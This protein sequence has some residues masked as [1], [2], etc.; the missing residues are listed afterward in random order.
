M[1]S[2]KKI[3][4]TSPWLA[5][6]L[7]KVC[8]PG[9]RS[10]FLNGTNSSTNRK[11]KLARCCVDEILLTCMLSALINRQ[12]SSYSADCCC[13]QVAANNIV[14]ASFC[15]KVSCAV[16][17]NSWTSRRLRFKAKGEVSSFLSNPHVLLVWLSRW[18]TPIDNTS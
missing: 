3:A 1:S 16:L 17:L 15:E 6:L 2:N 11:E 10:G 14:A 7:A 4:R 18:S 9:K 13:Q 12:Q 8:T 5:S